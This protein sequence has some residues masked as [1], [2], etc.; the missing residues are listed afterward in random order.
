MFS[1]CT[2]PKLICI[3]SE[4]SVQDVLYAL[5]V[6]FMSC[7]CIT[8]CLN[9]V[10]AQKRNDNIYFISF[11]KE[12]LQIVQKRYLGGHCSEGTITGGAVIL[13]V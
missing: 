1:V 8:E 6:K 3:G 2:T 5:Y 12:H 10:T 11:A 9:S 7:V 13:R 4:N